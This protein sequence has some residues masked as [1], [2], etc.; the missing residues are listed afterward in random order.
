MNKPAPTAKA[1][2]D[3]AHEISSPDERKAYLDEACAGAPEL[4]R[5]VEALLRAYD[6]AGSFLQKPAIPLPHTG[7][8]QPG[9]TP[10]DRPSV[11]P[12]TVDSQLGTVH[13]Q[14]P[15]G[16]G[17]QVGPYRLVKLL[18]EGGMGAVYL[19]EQEQPIRRQVALKIIKPGMD[20]AQ[21]VARFEAERQALTLMD[22]P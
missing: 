4:R 11:W 13:T 21:V 9:D 3:H 1:V 5:K 16:V 12:E 8:Y 15:E 18:G 19:A 2:F 17:A 6:E 20:S 7:P 22:H 10:G 14:P